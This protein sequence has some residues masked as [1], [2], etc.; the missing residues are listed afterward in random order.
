[1]NEHEYKTRFLKRMSELQVDAAI[2]QAEYDAHI[3]SNPNIWDLDQS[4][5]EEDADECMSYWGD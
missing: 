4:M 2:A 3:E 1:M 5:P